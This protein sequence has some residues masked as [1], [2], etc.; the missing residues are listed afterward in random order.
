MPVD[1]Q[2]VT[3]NRCIEKLNEAGIIL[4]RDADRDLAKKHRATRL[5]ELFSTGTGF[6]KTK[7]NLNFISRKVIEDIAFNHKLK[8]EII[9]SSK[10][11]SN[12]LYILRK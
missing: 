6:N 7:Y 11:T 10:L 9:R 2:I 8:L 1:Q 12:S 4:I 5:T 3:I